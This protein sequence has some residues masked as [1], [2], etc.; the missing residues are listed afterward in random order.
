MD[1]LKLKDT[2]LEVLKEEEIGFKIYKAMVRV[3]YD[4]DLLM[5]EVGD[6]IRSLPTVTIVTNI[7]HDEENGVAVYS[8]KALTNKT[9]QEAFEF[10]RQQS[11][12][13][14]KRVKKFEIGVKTIQIED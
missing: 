6:M 14:L 3:T 11:I 7:S 8:V 10:V 4:P 5:N 12:K 1:N 13:R 2:I 9:G